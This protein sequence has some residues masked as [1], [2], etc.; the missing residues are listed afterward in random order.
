MKKILGVFALLLTVA[1][2][3]AMRLIASAGA[4]AFEK[5]EVDYLNETIF[6]EV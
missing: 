2:I 5:V 1:V 3:G 6:V 4:S